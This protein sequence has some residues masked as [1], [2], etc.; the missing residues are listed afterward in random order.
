MKEKER[1]EVLE[2][3]EGLKKFRKEFDNPNFNLWDFINYK[4]DFDLAF[5]FCKLFFPDFIQVEG[6]VLLAEKF[7]PASFANWKNV[8]NQ[9]RHQLEST[10]NRT[11]V[12]DLFSESESSV[13]VNL[14][15]C[16][17]IGKYLAKSWASAL[18][19]N[20]PEKKFDIRFSTEPNDYGPTI[21]FYQSERD[22]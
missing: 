20:F 12:Y 19:E 18:K 2:K 7:E 8:L 21:T 5:A 9:D 3:I 13:E 6:C 15:M 4:S 1:I 16:E 10:L 22:I 11:H 17:E 14:E